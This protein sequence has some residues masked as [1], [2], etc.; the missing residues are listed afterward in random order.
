MTEEGIWFCNTRN[1][2]AEPTADM[3]IILTLATVRDTSRSET[4]LK[5]G[6]WRG[7]HVPSKDPSGLT[8]GIVGLGAIGK[9]GLPIIQPTLSTKYRD[10][11]YLI[12]MA[13]ET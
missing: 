3:A 5:E 9:V 7:D 11:L 6:K 10:M 2:V 12:S 13:L 4:G 1:A 8:L